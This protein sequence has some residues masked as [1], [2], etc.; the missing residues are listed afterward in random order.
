MKLKNHPPI[1]R[2][3]AGLKVVIRLFISPGRKRFEAKIYDPPASTPEPTVLDKPGAFPVKK[4]KTFFANPEGRYS[5]T[6][7]YPMGSGT[8][9]VVAFSPGLGA[10]GQWYQWIGEHLASHGYIVLIFTVP[11]PLIADTIQ[12]E[13]GFVSAFE[14]LEHENATSSSA[15][16]GRVN[17]GKRAV[18]GHS[19]GAASALAVA[20]KV[21]VNA[22]VS[23]APAPVLEKSRLRAIMAPTQIQVG[24]F[25]CISGEKTA[26]S[27]YNE[28]T[29][30][31]RQL[32]TLNGANHLDFHD[33]NSLGY[34]A[35]NRADHPATADTANFTQ[36]LSRRYFTAWLER[37]LKGDSSLEQYLFGKNAQRDLESGQLAV[38]QF[39]QT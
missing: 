23:F 5:T 25:D 28:L 4:L 3:F 35:G 30:A 22:V 34:T 20:T 12:Q 29:V 36:R 11:I 21:D 26:A 37:F 33:V 15:L 19:L 31:P 13:A 2:L 27:Y 14:F 1:W 17:V 9:P 7:Y 38:L 16:F 24:S 10:R 8:H 6:I 39:R 32:L 18:M